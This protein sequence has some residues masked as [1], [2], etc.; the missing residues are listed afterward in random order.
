MDLVA[1]TDHDTIDGCLEFLSAHPD[2][3]DFIMGEEVSCRF[4]D[5][6]I[7]VHLGVYGMTE[8]L[9]RDAAAAPRQRLRCQ[10]PACATPMCSS[11]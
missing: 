3:P 9:H 4:P 2:C 10:P 1:L 6:D 7:E 11:P 8:A 5:T